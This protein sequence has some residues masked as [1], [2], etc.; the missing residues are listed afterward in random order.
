M[1]KSDKRPG[2]FRPNH[3]AHSAFA[4]V[5][6]S[7]WF[8]TRVSHRRCCLRI[9]D[10]HGAGCAYTWAK[11]LRPL[12]KKR[13]LASIASKVEGHATWLNGEAI[14]YRLAIGRPTV[15]GWYVQ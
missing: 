8:A 6:W 3:P 9:L 2:C 15:N 13:L 12:G 1:M 11:A 4:S 5:S 7:G 10:L 14:A